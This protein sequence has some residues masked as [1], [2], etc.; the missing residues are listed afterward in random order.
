VGNTK[1]DI[2]ST[3]IKMAGS[4]AADINGGMVNINC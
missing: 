2:S 4:A 3:S 1:M